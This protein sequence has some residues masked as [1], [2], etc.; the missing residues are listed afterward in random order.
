[1]I[2]ILNTVQ[3]SADLHNF[4]IHPNK[5]TTAF[6]SGSEILFCDFVIQIICV[7]F[8]CTYVIK[9]NCIVFC[10]WEIQDILLSRFKP[11]I[12]SRCQYRWTNRVICTACGFALFS[13]STTCVPF[14][15]FLCQRLFLDNQYLVITQIPQEWILRV[16]CWRKRKE[17][18]N[19]NKR[20]QKENNEKGKKRTLLSPCFLQSS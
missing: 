5:W 19:I 20:K 13:W 14:V 18:R 6:L 10:Q 3:F 7:R 4:L 17:K 2:H 9:W 12:N 1:M 8:L 16:S 15:V 11:D